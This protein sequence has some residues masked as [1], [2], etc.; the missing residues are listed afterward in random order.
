MPQDIF[1]F[2]FFQREW[3]KVHVDKHTPWLPFILIIEAILLMPK[4]TQ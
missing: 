3:K 2:F 4:K 1:P